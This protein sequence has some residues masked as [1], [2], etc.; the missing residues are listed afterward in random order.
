MAF[1]S[2][3]IATPASP[4]A[5]ERESGVIFKKGTA[6]GIAFNVLPL[7]FTPYVRKTDG[8]KGRITSIKINLKY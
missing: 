1:T 8:N 4:I 7:V 6:V 2:G 3:E 5:P